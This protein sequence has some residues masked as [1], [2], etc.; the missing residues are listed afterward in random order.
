MVRRRTVA[1]GELAVA[2]LSLVVQVYL[3]NSL[4]NDE[5][6]WDDPTHVSW[7]GLAAGVLYAGAYRWVRDRDV[8]G[9][10]T[11]R[12]RGLLLSLCS[13]ALRRRLL[14]RTR[15]FRNNFGIGRTAGTLGYRLWYGL[16]RPLPETDE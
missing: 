5:E 16:V 9:V 8:G 10:R 15:E 13:L 3:W 14:P 2:A 6:E 12:R 1:L 7:R 11:D 4:L